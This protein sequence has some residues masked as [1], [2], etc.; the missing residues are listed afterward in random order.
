[1]VHQRVHPSA[2]NRG[3]CSAVENLKTAV[4]PTESPSAV[5]YHLVLGILNSVSGKMLLPLA[6]TLPWSTTTG[7][8]VLWYI[9]LQF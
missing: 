7:K 1:M 2:S 6:A 9:L 4:K 8:G 5:K 3:W